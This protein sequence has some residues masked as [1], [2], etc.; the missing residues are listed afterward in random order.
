MRLVTKLRLK[1]PSKTQP[2][3]ARRI[4]VTGR[5]R[6]G[7]K[8]RQL[9]KPKT[10]LNRPD[11]GFRRCLGSLLW[12]AVVLHAA[13]V[14]PQDTPFTAQSGS[15]PIIGPDG[16]YVFNHIPTSNLIVEAQI[17]PRIIIVGS[18]GD[19]TRR[20]LA[21]IRRPVW[22]WQ[23]STTPMVRLRLFNEE[24]S[25]VRTPSYMP[26]ATVQ[27][28][29]LR[30]VSRADESDEE[31]FSRGPVEMWLI[32]VIPFGHHSNGQNG[33][34]FTSQ[35]RQAGDECV[36]SARPQSSAINTT[37][38]SFST[39]YIQAMVQYGRLY[40]DSELA[41]ET[42]YATRREW[43]AGAGFQVNPEG[44]VAGSID[45][46]LSELYGP[47][48]ILFEGMVAARDR[49][50]C[51]RLE[52]DV[53]LQYIVD[54]PAGVP[55]FTT[56]AETAC[57]PRAWGGTGLFVRFYRGQDYYNLGFAERISRLQFG[58]TLQR[59]MFLSFKIRPQ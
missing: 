43:R 18:F 38:G 42:E 35:S 15:R 57:L 52:A 25:P 48:R 32:D 22:G 12:L 55:A 27:I 10:C 26:K 58:F 4:F 28:A 19:V 20:L 29:S 1:P 30:N 5:P 8:L 46:S 11:I 49:W 37:D 56:R 41:P 23:L 7:R 2:R 34:L 6:S 9:L 47:T 59:G 16:T 21:A 50:R 14:S 36:E 17:A 13:P 39:N 53:H 44:Y 45:H 51:G 33:C 40:L 54:A 3:R 31:E 24:S